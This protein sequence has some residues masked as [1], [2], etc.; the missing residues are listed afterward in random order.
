M[1][2]NF[3][4]EVFETVP[5]NHYIIFEGAVPPQTI[6]AIAHWLQQFRATQLTDT[7]WCY[8]VTAYGKIASERRK[9]LQEVIQSTRGKGGDPYRILVLSPF[10]QGEFSRG[11]PAINF[12][13]TGKIGIGFNQTNPL[14]EAK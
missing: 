2:N 7:I 1:A 5:L 9:S 8:R 4:P 13:G 10:G 11:M 6:E 14:D 3:D 12:P